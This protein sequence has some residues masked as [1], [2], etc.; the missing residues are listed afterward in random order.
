[1]P[2]IPGD[3]LTVGP[4]HAATRAGAAG[5]TPAPASG[6]Q[7]STARLAPGAIIAG[8]YRL[9]ASLGKGGMGEVY[10]AD[11]LTLDLPVA[12]KFVPDLDA[13]RD[14][15][16]GAQRLAQFH[17]ELRTARQVSHKNVCRLY[18][19]GEA[20]GHRFLTMEYVDGEDLA[21]LLRRIGRLPQDKALEI[22]RQLCAGLSAAHDRGVVHRDLKPANVMIDGE[23]NVRITDFGLA[24][25]GGE[26]AAPAGTPQYMAPEQF[27]G[28]AASIK[29]DLFALGLVLFEIFT[30]RRAFE[31][32][33]LADL[34]RI[35]ES[36]AIATPTSF[37][38]DLDPAIERVILRCLERDP[39]RRPGSALAVAA[40]LPGANPLADALA[41]GETPSPDLLAAAAEAQAMPVGRAL[42]LMGALAAAL[43]I[44]GLFSP[45][46]TLADLVSLDKPPAVLADRAEQLLKTL[47]Y[48]DAPTDEAYGFASS[49]DYLRWVARTNPAPGRWL[50]M[51]A[52]GSSA[53]LFWYRSSPREMLPAR[54]GFT[55]T[56]TDPPA[57]TTG[58]TTV[59]LDTSGRLQELHVVPVQ[60]DPDTAPAP[61]PRWAAAFDAAGLDMAAFHETAPEWT[62]PNFADTRAAWIGPLPGSDIEL[63]VE[64]AAYRGRIVSVY[65]LGPWARASRMT[66]A[67]QSALM[68]AMGA[69][70]TMF[71]ISLLL[72]AAAVARRHLRSNKADRRAAARLAVGYMIVQ[73]VGWVAGSH[74]STSINLESS[75]FFK[76]VA[77]AALNGGGL[78]VLYLAIEPYGRRFWPDGLLGWSRL[79][80]GHIRDPR[81]GGD[82]LVGVALGS[83]MLMLDLLRSIGPPLAGIS[84]ALPLLG[85]SL[86]SLVSTGLLVLEWMQQIFNSIESALIVVLLFIA[87]RLIVRRTWL[88]IVI[89]IVVVSLA[90]SNAVAPGGNLWVDAAFS[91]LVTSLMTFAIFRFGLLVT[92]VMLLV[93]NIPTAIPFVAGSAWASSPGYLSFGLVAALACF[94]FYAARAGQP[95]LGTID[96]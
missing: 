87:L 89:G 8:R 74:H 49:D 10:R 26:D 16:A 90:S 4:S 32:K 92:T 24:V 41:A 1:M 37:V 12:L 15:A 71:W 5:V 75:A 33:T 58:M 73:A 40:A 29:T 47:G 81:V 54:L 34:K 27:T 60:H 45:R 86:G 28:R 63:R 80:S 20:D 19:L 50:S 64:A 62:P 95:L 51:K 93:D 59:M 70:A 48:T 78:W 84:P 44:Y 17:N 68:V 36:G 14:D 88:A 2:D 43:V 72:G 56:P 77:L 55:I 18:D 67:P 61:A 65:T 53:M 91:A 42:A 85:F 11:D 7:A 57:T 96:A 31:A 3:D 22:A 38:R 9:V 66:P 23:G 25:A 46:A 82:I 21:S 83:V 69:F 6:S 79:F 76:M 52:A 30:G 94:G 39:D 13:G 35:H